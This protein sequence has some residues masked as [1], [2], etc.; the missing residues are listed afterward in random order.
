MV[1]EFDTAVFA[2][3][4]GAYTKTP[5][6]TQFGFHVILVEDKRTQAPP[7]LVDVH[8]DGKVIPALVS[9][10][11]NSLMFVLDRVTGKP[12][13]GVEERPVPPSTVPGEHLSPTQPFPVLPAP[14]GQT[15]L[16]RDNLYKGEPNHQAWCEKLVDDN[17][18]KLGAIYMPLEVDRYTVSLPGTQGGVNYYGGAYDPT[19]HLFVANVNNLAQPMRMV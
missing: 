3:E 11:K 14:L 9:V 18:M 17:K 8:R 6:K 7:T 19:R 10:N 13:F 16:S 15:N 5:V 12:I 1:P 2:L 4:K